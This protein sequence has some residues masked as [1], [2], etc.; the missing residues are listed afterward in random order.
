MS[1]PSVLC[2]SVVAGV[3]AL[4]FATE[5]R[6]VAD[7]GFPPATLT[8]L[9]VLPKDSRPANVI[10]LMKEFTRALGVRC[11]HC[12]AG[13]DGQPLTTFDF[14]S[15]EKAAKATARA[16]LRLVVEINDSLDRAVPGAT[17][18]VQCWT[19]HAG[20]RTPRR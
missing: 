5:S 7:Q 19:C 6:L 16:M 3:T 20:Q 15:D 18:R 2:V 1:S 12:H 13:R 9:R 14:V 4:L 10:N 11:D 17:G 8:N